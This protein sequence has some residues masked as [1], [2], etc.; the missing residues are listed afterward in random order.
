MTDSPAPNSIPS[1]DEDAPQP[2]VSSELEIRDEPQHSSIEEIPAFSEQLRR[3]P[4]IIESLFWIFGFVVVQLGLTLAF[5]IVTLVVMAVQV[6]QFL[7]RLRESPETFETI[8]LKS[9]P[10]ML[11]IVQ[12]GSILAA[13]LATRLRW[14]KLWKTS[15]RYNR[16]SISHLFAIIGLMLPVQI[17]SQAVY[18]QVSHHWKLFLEQYP[19]FG[20]FEQFNLIESAPDMLS[21]TALPIS[22]LAFVI[23]PAIT[24]ELMFR[25][26]IGNGLT[27]RYGIGLG[28]LL[29]SVFFAIV[30]THPVHAA[31]VFGLGGVIYWVYL[32]TRSIFAPMLLHFLNNG[33]AIFLALNAPAEVE[34]SEEGI[35]LFLSLCSL[36]SVIVICLYLGKSRSYLVSEAGKRVRV[37]DEWKLSPGRLNQFQAVQCSPAIPLTLLTLFVSLGTSG[38]ILWALLSP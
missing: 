37:Q 21:Q 33:L 26:A 7:N 36:L 25:G 15:I 1:S 29:S 14:G 23:A 31:A 30:H 11:G 27:N 4:G 18:E 9:Q 3:G 10:L 24:E 6:P 22:I 35:P 2:E 12:G 19:K 16:L 13:I 5:V 38:L 32:T 17:L 34:P 20:F 8:L 28:L